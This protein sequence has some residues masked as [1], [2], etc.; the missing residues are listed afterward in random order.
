MN[1]L[2]LY[3]SYT[4]D[5]SLKLS[6]GDYPGGVA[7]WG[8]LPAAFDTTNLDFDRGVHVHARLSDIAK[9]SID[10][11]YDTVE[12]EW[13][14]NSFVIDERAAVHFTMASIFDIEIISLAC[15]CCQQDIVS[16]GLNAVIPQHHHSC[17][18]CGHINSTNRACVINPIVALKNKIGDPQIKRQATLPNRSIILDVERFPGGIQIWG[19]NPSIIWTARRLEESAIHVHAYN[20]NGK[21]I[22]DNTYSTVIMDGQSLDI[23]MIRVL[24]I[25]QAVPNLINTITTVCCPNCDV[26][27]FDQGIDAIVAHTARTCNHCK[28]SF[29]HQAVISNPALDILRTLQKNG[30]NI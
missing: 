2:K 12:V 14:G 9:K 18:G 30:V 17:Q 29:V 8:A 3:K 27:Q 4:C 7:I 19:S 1:S 16:T 15:C 26:A 10:A 22:I 6:I 24:Q 5:Q 21:R 13:R 11:T 25:Q 28:K 20:V 23:E